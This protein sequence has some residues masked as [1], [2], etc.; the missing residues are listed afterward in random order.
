VDKDVEL[1]TA[2]QE[3]FLITR[4]RIAEQVTGEGMPRVYGDISAHVLNAMTGKPANGVAIE[5]HEIW[6]EQ[7]HKVA[8]AATTADGRAIVMSGRPLPIGRYEMRFALG[9]YFRKTG[10]VTS[11]Q[12]FFHVVPL[13]LFISK[14]E[15]SYH[16]P[17]IGTPFSY[18]THG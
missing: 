1:A 15:S 10:A 9:D 3:E 13:R 16:F 14:P 4:L 11:D 12:P 18:T 7:S 2:I 8:Q 6:G 5:L 17:M